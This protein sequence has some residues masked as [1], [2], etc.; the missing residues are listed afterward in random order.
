MKDERIMKYIPKSKH[1]GIADAFIDSDGMWIFL[2]DGWN[3]DRMDVKCHV[4]HEDYIKDLRWQISGIRK[5]E[6]NENI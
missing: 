6:E 3:A 4:I 1:E 2:K 5:E